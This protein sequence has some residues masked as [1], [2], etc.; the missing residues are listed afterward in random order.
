MATDPSSPGRG[1]GCGREF[2]NPIGILAVPNGSR[3]QIAV[4]N[5]GRLGGRS[6]RAIGVVLATVGAVV[7]E[8]V[9]LISKQ[10]FHVEQSDMEPQSWSAPIQG[11]TRRT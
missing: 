10:V 9:Q 11:V 7:V 8:K 3:L 6:L 1:A 2:G 5:F 4:F